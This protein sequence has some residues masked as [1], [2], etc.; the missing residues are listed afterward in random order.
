MNIPGHGAMVPWSDS[1]GSKWS[2][3]V[4]LKGIKEMKDAHGHSFP[5]D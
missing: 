3:A 2:K 5:T 4:R 1:R